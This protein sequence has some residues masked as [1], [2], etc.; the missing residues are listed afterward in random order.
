MP[1]SQCQNLR[2]EE[3][4]G[5][6]ADPDDNKLSRSFRPRSV[7]ADDLIREIPSHSRARQ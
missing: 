4:E 5:E 2:H 7:R 6:A 1:S 3:N